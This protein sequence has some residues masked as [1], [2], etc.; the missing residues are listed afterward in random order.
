MANHRLG[1][2]GPV[3]DFTVQFVA[4]IGVPGRAD[5]VARLPCL[6]PEASSAVINVTRDRLKRVSVI[7]AFQIGL[8]SALSLPPF[9]IVRADQL[10]Q[11]APYELPCHGR[12]VAQ[13]RVE[14]DRQ[15]VLGYCKSPHNALAD[16]S[17]K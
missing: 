1:M 17:G 7:I 9:N 5:R 11:P 14:F 8:V 4:I 2:G 15:H 3:A 12:A 13:C 16:V 6:G 10:F